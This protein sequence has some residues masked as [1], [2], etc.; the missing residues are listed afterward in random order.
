[1]A[2]GQKDSANPDI[3]KK[4]CY[5]VREIITEIYN[6]KIAKINRVLYGGSVNLKNI[7]E[8]I[9]IS[10]VDGIGS[11]RSLLNPLDFVKMIRIVEKESER[12]RS[13]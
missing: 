10:E 11:G 3:I 13:M 2:I 1:M 4:R 6:E 12:R 5:K 9:R 7:S 8:I